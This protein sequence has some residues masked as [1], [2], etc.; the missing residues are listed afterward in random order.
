MLPHLVWC[1]CSELLS[2]VFGVANTLSV[3]LNWGGDF[4]IS[5]VAQKLSKSITQRMVTVNETFDRR[6]SHWWFVLGCLF[7]L[8]LIVR[9][10]LSQKDGAIQPTAVLLAAQRQ[11]LLLRQ[12]NCVKRTANDSVIRTVVCTKPSRIQQTKQLL[13][14][15]PPHLGWESDQVTAVLRTVE[16]QSAIRQAPSST[17]VPLSTNQTPTI[18]LPYSETV[19]VQPTLALTMLRHKQTKTARIWFLLRALDK[20]G[21]GWLDMH[22]VKTYLTQ[23]GSA[24][25]TC[26]WRQL[27]NLLT[28]GETVFWHRNNGRIWLRAVAKVATH[29]GVQRFTGHPVAVPIA[30]FR[31]KIGTV[32]AHLYAVFHNGRQN[33]PIARETIQALSD[34]K[35]QTQ[36]QYEQ[37]A[38]IHKQHNFA[39][40][41]RL[42]TEK[43]Q[44]FAWQHRRALFHWT[45]YQGHYGN[46]GQTY[47]AWQL[48]NSYISPYQP[49]SR[50]SQKRLNRKLVDLLT[51]GTV[52]N[53]KQEIDDT[54]V[55][56]EQRYYCNGQAAIKAHG[57]LQTTAYWPNHHATNGRYLQ[58]HVI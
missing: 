50:G 44:D 7:C 53:G 33:K 14:T 31:Q 29:F 24:L 36:R 25:R 40:G 54:F 48:P 38:C 8:C 6:M 2:T 26:S 56:Y 58:W 19:T 15:L 47:L 30:I 57:R 16:E 1:Y 23:K 20:C 5:K 9:R 37:R 45:D 11:L 41:P 46:I 35:P 27:R 42:T 51:K 4:C 32:R 52:G 12:A 22:E 10:L 17:T 34:I 21:R 55:Q 3:P 49:Q 43:A 28:Q 13:H 18:P 39:I